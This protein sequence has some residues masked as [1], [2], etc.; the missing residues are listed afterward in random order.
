MSYLDAGKN[1]EEWLK[2]DKEMRK[3]LQIFRKQLDHEVSLEFAPHPMKHF[4]KARNRDLILDVT[5]PKYSFIEY[6]QECTGGRDGAVFLVK[7]KGKEPHGVYEEFELKD[8]KR[9]AG[10]ICAFYGNVMGWPLIY[11]DWE[12]AANEMWCPLM[13][14]I[15]NFKLTEGFGIKE[16]D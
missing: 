16:E 15:P 2:R 7:F 14:A 6:I 3:Y 12:W 9:F 11:R 5:P 10:H 1:E 8:A 4:E 13:P